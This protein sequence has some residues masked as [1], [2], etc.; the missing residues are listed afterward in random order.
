[1]W[2]VMIFKILGGVAWAKLDL[3]FP[4]N[5]SNILKIIKNHVKYNNDAWNYS[6]GPRLQTVT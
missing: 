3:V 4:F 1:M 2:F 5:V 6:R